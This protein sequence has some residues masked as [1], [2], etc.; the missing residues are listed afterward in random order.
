MNL[1]EPVLDSPNSLVTVQLMSR[2]E[3]ECRQVEEQSGSLAYNFRMAAGD[4]AVIAKIDSTVVGVCWLAFDRYLDQDTETNV[5]LSAD[6]V[7]LYGAWVERQYRGR[8]IYRDIVSMAS[9]HARRL[10][11]STFLFAVDFSNHVS[12]STHESLGANWIG[13][14]YGV[15]LLGLGGFRLSLRRT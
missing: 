4:C 5:E 15:K 3:T 11:K 12:R 6:D 14:V 2:D 10:N 13:Y 9:E 1:V 7:W 8:G